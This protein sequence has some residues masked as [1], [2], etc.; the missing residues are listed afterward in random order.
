MQE[1]GA[2]IPMAVLGS[3][4]PCG[5]PVRY[6]RTLSLFHRSVN[7]GHAR[8]PFCVHR[9]SL[10]DRIGETVRTLDLFDGWNFDELV[11]HYGAIVQTEIDDCAAA[12]H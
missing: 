7:W 6:P 4:Q 9:G 1:P 10:D 11:A 2:G 12:A 3:P 8:P 5:C